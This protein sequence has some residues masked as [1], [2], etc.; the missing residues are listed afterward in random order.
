MAPPAL[1]VREYHFVTVPGG[2]EAVTQ[3]VGNQRAR[4]GT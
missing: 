3:W 4:P 1:R 2:L